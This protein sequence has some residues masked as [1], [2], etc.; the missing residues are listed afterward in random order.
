MK[1]M[2]DVITEHQRP[3]LDESL[4]SVVLGK[5]KKTIHPLHSEGI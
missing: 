5:K 4:F 3:L 1:V 2:I